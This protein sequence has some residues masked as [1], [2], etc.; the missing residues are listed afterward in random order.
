[1]NK[2]NLYL[3]SIGYEA[4]CLDHSINLPTMPQDHLCPIGRLEVVIKH[5]MQKVEKLEDKIA[6]FELINGWDRK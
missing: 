1:M 5:L 3:S 4:I 6:N 2:C